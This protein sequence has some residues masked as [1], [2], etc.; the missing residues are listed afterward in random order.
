MRL[1]DVIEPV[2]EDILYEFPD[3]IKD[4]NEN[5]ESNKEGDIGE[6]VFGRAIK[7]SLLEIGLMYNENDIPGSFWIKHYKSRNQ[8][9]PKDE[10]RGPDFR[11]EIIDNKMNKHVFLIES[12]NWDGYDYKVPHSTFKDS[13]LDRFLLHDPKHKCFWI[14]TMNKGNVDDIIDDC[15]KHGIVILP[16]DCKITQDF[17][18]D[19][20]KPIIISFVHHFTTI[21][22]CYFGGL[23]NKPY[24]KSIADYETPTEGLRL[25]LKYGVPDK[26]IHK[27]FG[28]KV[29]KK[30]ISKIKNQ[31]NKE[32]PLTDRRTKRGRYIRDIW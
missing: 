8:K 17:T 13:I 30:Y 4:Y 32:M 18:K 29:T 2:I 28:D 9:R 11:V 23:P 5:E 31:L 27:V 12:K 20:L 7:Y 14:T 22:S 19:D 10:R 1:D 21:F 25:Y 16:I 6:L 24:E 15:K 3:I 26:I